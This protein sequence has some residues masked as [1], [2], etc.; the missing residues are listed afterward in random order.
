VKS[1]PRGE[2]TSAVELSNVSVHGFWLLVDGREFYVPFEEF[3]W[4][5]DATIAEL[6]LIERPSKDHLFW[7]RLDIDLSLDSLEHPD[8]YPLVS[9]PEADR[10]LPAAAHAREQPPR[11]R[12]RKRR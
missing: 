2:R 10:S 7:P 4:F 1:G 9:R 6:A 3:P 12:T 11:Y 8:R 5:R